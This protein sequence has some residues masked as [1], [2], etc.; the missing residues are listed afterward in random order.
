MAQETERCNVLRRG[1]A[2]RLF[3]T[4]G[5]SSR[6]SITPP[7][8]LCMTLPFFLKLDAGQFVR[9]ACRWHSRRSDNRIRGAR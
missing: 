7:S 4:H 1:R 6:S 2:Y 3:V 8:G 9:A 5:S